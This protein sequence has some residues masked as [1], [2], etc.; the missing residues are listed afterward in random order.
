[1]F[2][3]GPTHDTLGQ[4]LFQIQKLGYNHVHNQYKIGQTLIPEMC[5]ERLNISLHYY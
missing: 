4:L 1:M 5:Q 3:I 2:L